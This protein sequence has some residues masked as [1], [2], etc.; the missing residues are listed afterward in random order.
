M[1]WLETIQPSEKYASKF[2]CIRNVAS[3]DVRT[4]QVSPYSRTASGY[5]SKLPTSKMIRLADGK[6]RR[7]YVC[8][9]SN[10]G[11]AYIVLN[12]RNVLLSD[13]AI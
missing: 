12:G 9:Y 8:C 4:T 6:W 13:T 5:G 11:S 7:V 3:E 2:Q 10:A 1:N